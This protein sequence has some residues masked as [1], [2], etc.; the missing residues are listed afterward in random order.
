M[1]AVKLNAVTILYFCGTFSATRCELMTTCESCQEDP[2]CGWCDDGKKRGRGRCMEGAASAPFST[3]GLPDVNK[4]P[5]NH[6]FFSDCPC[7]F[8]ECAKY[9]FLPVDRMILLFF[10]LFN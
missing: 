10:Y 3:N 1:D 4:C 9:A 6:W 8:T 5:S 2:K 7:K